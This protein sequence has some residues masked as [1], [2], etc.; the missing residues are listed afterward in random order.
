MRLDTSAAHRFSALAT[1]LSRLLSNVAVF[2]SGMTVPVRRVTCN[3]WTGSSRRTMVGPRL[4]HTASATLCFVARASC[5]IGSETSLTG[6]YAQ[7][8][9]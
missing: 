1:V 9:R 5:S 2:A 8:P 3:G 6:S 4:P 7:Q